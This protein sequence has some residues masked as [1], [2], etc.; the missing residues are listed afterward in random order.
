MIEPRRDWGEYVYQSDLT[1]ELYESTTAVYA[2][3]DVLKQI[4]YGTSEVNCQG[5]N[6]QDILRPHLEEMLDIAGKDVDRFTEDD[7]DEADDT[8]E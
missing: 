7:E 2:L 3:V 1:E 4:K 5:H 8:D 6:I